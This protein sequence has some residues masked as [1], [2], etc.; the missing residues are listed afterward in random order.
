MRRGRGL[1]E[2]IYQFEER[3]V[4]DGGL[5]V[6]G[7]GQPNNR[8]QCGESHADLSHECA[9]LNEQA[10]YHA[11]R[12]LRCNSRANLKVVINEIFEAVRQEQN[13]FG[14]PGS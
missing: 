3:V 11:L 12:E 14:A 10:E 13:S 9:P 8:L 1:I 7:A 4:G 6:R 5:R 2:R